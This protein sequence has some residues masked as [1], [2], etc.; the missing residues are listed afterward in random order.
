MNTPGNRSYASGVSVVIPCYDEQDA[1]SKTI[2]DVEAALRKSGLEWEIIAVNDGSRDG[3]GE[4]LESLAGTHSRLRVIQNPFNR[5]YGASLK[6]GISEA[7]F[8]RIVI[9]D[10]D[11]TYPNDQIPELLRLLERADMVVGARTGANVNIPFARR[12]VKWLLLKYARW[13]SRADIK[14]VN[15]GLRAVWV[16]HVRSVWSM[17]PN[18]F[19]FTTTIT[20]AS[21]VNQLH[22]VYHPIDYFKRVGH[23]SIRPVRDTAR[24]FFLV[25]R[26]IMFFKPLQVFGLLG[27]TLMILAVIVGLVG[28]LAVDKIPEVAAISLFTTGVNFLG[29]GL[30]GDLVNSQR[31]RS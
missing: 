24:F 4:K 29:L 11:G 18:G 1:V 12:P 25:A 13:L 20:I 30:I 21:H 19:S 22:V 28:K 6:A 3:T 7:T 14:D 23:S 10:A 31:F 27:V 9:T 15:S 26:T 2:D 8:D 5:G 17:L 16:K